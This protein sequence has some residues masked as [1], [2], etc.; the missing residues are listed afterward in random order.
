MNAT[1]QQV[2]GGSKYSNKTLLGNWS[3]ELAVGESKLQ[4][5]KKR[6]ESGSLALRKQELKIARCMEIVPHTYS[7]D[8]LVRFGD[9]VILRHDQTGTV[10][11]CDPFED[12]VARQNKFLVTA[13]LQ[14]SVPARARNV[15][16]LVRPEPALRSPDDDG[17]D[18]VLK[19][20]QAFVLECNESLLIQPGSNLLAPLL[21]LAST[22][23]NERNVTRNTN[24]QMVYLSPQCDAEC[25]WMAIV[26]SR[27]KSNAADRFL[28]MGT[29]ASRLLF[30][31]FVLCP[32]LVL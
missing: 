29:G 26:P 30:V 4:G 7:E 22:K 21:Y 20:G 3:E 18:A 27:G 19:V 32:C 24:R 13:S 14:P 12:Q 5:F 6:S 25:V 31:L 11:S 17:S 8:G 1:P 10:L 2:S 16:R 28:S 9:T 23:K 15:F